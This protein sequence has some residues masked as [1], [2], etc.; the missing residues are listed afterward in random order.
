MTERILDGLVLAIFGV[1]SIA[2]VPVDGRLR[3]ALLTV[4]LVFA[5][6]ASGLVLGILAHEWIRSFIA[7][8]NRRLPGRVTGFAL[9]KAS[10][11]LGGLLALG[12]IPRI[13]GAIFITAIIWSLEVGFYYLVGLAVWP[14]F[15]IRIA[16]LFVV[17]VN[18]ASIIPLSMGGIGTIEAIAPPFLIGSGVA[19]AAALAMVLIQHVTQLVFTTLTGGIAYL[20]GGF[21][22]ISLSDPKAALGPSPERSLPSPVAETTSTA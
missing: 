1:I 21:Y 13:L 17:V 20:A 10:H 15:S 19:P 6:L 22:R 3:W 12:T 2:L 18:F 8:A 9:N 14:I 7:A 4:S 11:F 16:V 5:G